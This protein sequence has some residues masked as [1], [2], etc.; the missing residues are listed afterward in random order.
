MKAIMTGTIA[1]GFGITAIILVDEEAEEVVIR[2]LADGQLAEAM[3]VFDPQTL[4]GNF[5]AAENG[6]WFVL[7][8][9]GIGNSNQLYGPFADLNA[10]EEF[11][12]H[13]ADGDDWDL[14]ELN[15]ASTPNEPNFTEILQHRIK[16]WLGG[17]NAPSELDEAS[18]EHIKTLIED[19][20]REGELCV[21]APGATPNSEPVEY[22]GWWNIEWNT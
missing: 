18:V 5:D 15:S 19:G 8:E 20:C 10:A 22:R 2:N 16:F 21:S 7:Y 6:T 3:D 4:E 12:K 9:G 13:N 17:R 1:D 14:F 11:A